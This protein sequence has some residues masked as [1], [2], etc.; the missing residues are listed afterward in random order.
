MA[1]LTALALVVAAASLAACDSRE[2]IVVYNWGEYIAEDTI[3]K[4]EAEYPQYR[5]VYRLFDDN[6]KMYPKIGKESFD[7][8]VPSDYMV[9]RLIKEGK[10]QKIDPNNIPNVATYLDESM[11][12]VVFDADPAISSSV[13]EYAVPYLYCSVGLIYNTTEIT[14]DDPEDPEEVW[15]IL[16][17]EQYKDRIGM[18]DSM[19]ESI[20]AALNYLGHSINSVD[21]DEL[22]AAKTLLVNQ[23]RNVAPI[24]GIDTLKDKYVS[25]EL[26]AG[27]AW[28][29]DYLVCT[30]A[31]EEAGEDPEM[32]GFAL[33][34]GSNFAVD[35]MCIPANAKNV[36]G[37]E[38]FINFM[39]ETEIALA[40]TLY[41]GY[42]SPHT[43]AVGQLPEEIRTDKKFYPDQKT[44]DSLEI[45]YSSE[46]IDT[47]Y[48]AIW[49]QIM[50]N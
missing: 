8:I 37:A 36:T 11:K 26:V 48:N 23:R 7:V 34:A 17:D 14:I 47:K 50:A 49:E 35:L 32:L 28:S 33:P 2:K 40:N 41:A 12:K 13:Y 21:D 29:G 43:A 38:R 19:R 6:E 42:S 44:F 31:L 20:G 9:V 3:E 30:D 1:W 24:F 16:F 4:F 25:G 39:Y 18:Y 22:T 46:E 45:Y 5:V 10:L 15:G 27:V